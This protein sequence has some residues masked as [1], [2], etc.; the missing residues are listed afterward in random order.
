[1]PTR[2]AGGVHACG[3]VDGEN[4]GRE[5]NPMLRCTAV[6]FFTLMLVCPAALA[7]SKPSANAIEIDTYENFQQPVV[8]IRSEMTI[9]G[10]YEYLKGMDRESENKKLDAMSELLQSSGTITAMSAE[11][12]SSLTADQQAVNELHSCEA[13]WFPHSEDAVSHCAPDSRKSRK[14]SEKCERPAEAGTAERTG[15]VTG[16]SPLAQSRSMKRGNGRAIS[17]CIL[18]LPFTSPATFGLANRK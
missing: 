7:R 5:K 3:F 13:D 1:M 17:S 11:A 4:H 2:I 15:P 16:Q 8:D 10:R 12:K 14:L 18:K 9:G 6:Q